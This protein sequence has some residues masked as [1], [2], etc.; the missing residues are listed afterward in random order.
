[1]PVKDF[2]VVLS[3]SEVVQ[4]GGG[5]DELVMGPTSGTPKDQAKVAC[6]TLTG[7][8][9]F[10][11]VVLVPVPTGST[12]KSGTGQALILPSNC[13]KAYRA[14]STV[15]VMTSAAVSFGFAT[16]DTSTCLNSNA[17]YILS[18]TAATNV[19]LSPANGVYYYNAVIY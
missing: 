8:K 14:G 9:W 15:D 1:M 10:D 4:K 7:A 2:S 18:G 3:F 5:T 6:N 12:L 16:E 11:K 17:P 13:F 19:P